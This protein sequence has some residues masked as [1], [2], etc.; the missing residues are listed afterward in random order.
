MQALDEEG[1]VSREPSATAGWIWSHG[2][3]RVPAESPPWPVF[4]L[5]EIGGV[6]RPALHDALPS[7]D[8]QTAADA[9]FG[10]FAKHYQSEQPGDAELLE[11]IGHLE[12]DALVNLVRAGAVPPREILPVGLR[13]L[14]ALAQ[15][16]RS[17]APSLLQPAA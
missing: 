16:C 12:G 13:L 11:R 6:L 4:S 17:N 5:S 1:G 14:S 15:L 2:A 8:A 9:L 3:E 10:A 7:L